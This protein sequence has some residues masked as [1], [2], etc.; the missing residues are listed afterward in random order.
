MLAPKAGLAIVHLGVKLR[1]HCDDSRPKIGYNRIC[2]G[3]RILQDR[4]CGRGWSQILVSAVAACRCET[5]GGLRD[6][7]HLFPRD[8]SS[9][10]LSHKD[11]HRA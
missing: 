3:T 2:A 5:R 9:R 8:L 6:D 1:A 4:Q 11:V 10:G 7:P